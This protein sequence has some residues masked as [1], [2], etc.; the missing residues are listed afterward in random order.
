MVGSVESMRRLRDRYRDSVEVVDVFVRQE[1]PGPRA[2]AYRT[3][4]DKLADAE[5][6]VEE[7]GID[8]TVAVD[9]LPGTV[10]RRYGGLSNPAY[11]I[12]ADGRVAF[13]ENIFNERVLDRAISNLLAGG[14]RGV[15]IRGS[16][17]APHAP[18]SLRGARSALAKGLPDSAID[19]VCVAMMLIVPAATVG[20]LAWRATAARRK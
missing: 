7:R 8:W 12:D 5:R 13:Y 14:R 6:Y 9:D 17:R 11:L 3:S 20:W 1:H 2:P 19:L 15:V 18:E 10:H 4:T 16:D